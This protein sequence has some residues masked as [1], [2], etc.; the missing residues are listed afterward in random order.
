[1]AAPPGE[2]QRRN[3]EAPRRRRTR[4]RPETEVDTQVAAARSLTKRDR[5][6]GTRE[7]SGRQR[8]DGQQLQS[9]LSS[10]AQ[11]EDGDVVDLC[12]GQVGG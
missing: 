6:N 3:R 7:Q 4:R 5:S 1:M 11:I 2:S 8:L 10:Q 12:R 9:R